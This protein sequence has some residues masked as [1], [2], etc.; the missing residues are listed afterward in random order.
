MTSFD[1]I[2]S[3]DLTPVASPGCGYCYAG[4]EYAALLHKQ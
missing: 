1:T 4:N 3:K 2:Q